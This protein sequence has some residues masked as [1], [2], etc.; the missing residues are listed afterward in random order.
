MTIMKMNLGIIG[1]LDFKSLGHQKVTKYY[2]NCIITEILLVISY[3]TSYWKKYYY[4]RAL[5]L[6]F[7]LGA[8]VLLIKKM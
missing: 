1:L 4:Y 6:L 5:R 3:T 8:L 2:T 7:F